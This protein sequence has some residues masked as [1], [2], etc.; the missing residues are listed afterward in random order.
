M[1]ARDG[2]APM[3]VEEHL[4]WYVCREVFES[5]ICRN[6]KLS[7]TM[8]GVGCLLK[9]SELFILFAENSQ[10]LLK[11]YV[12]SI[13]STFIYLVALNLVVNNQSNHRPTQLI[14]AAHNCHNVFFLNCSN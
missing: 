1:G 5:I 3:T 6:D 8:S 10:I 14:I 2:M 13:P 11:I 9:D 12:I 7:L 4:S